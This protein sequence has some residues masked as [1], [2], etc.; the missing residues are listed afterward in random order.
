M[1]IV[2]ILLLTLSTIVGF[3]Q[4]CQWDRFK[5]A[6]GDSPEGQ[7]FTDAIDADV[8]L[9]DDWEKLDNAD[10]RNVERQ[11]STLEPEQIGPYLKDISD[12][13]PLARKFEGG[14]ISVDSWKILNETGETGLVSRVDD[15]EFVDGYIKNSEK[16]PLQVTSEI[17]DAGGYNAWKVAKTGG[18][19]ADNLTG[20]LKSTYDDLVA[21]GLKTIDDG[22]I[23]KFTDEAGNELAKITDGEFVPTK[24]IAYFK[25]EVV[26]KT[27]TGHWLIKNGDEYG[28]DLGYKDG[29]VFTSEQVNAYHRGIGNH[30]P[31]KPLNNVYERDLQI[32]DKLYIVEYKNPIGTDI[33]SPNP[34]GW[35]SKNKIST[36]QELREDLAVLEGWKDA[37]QNGGLVLREYTVKKPLPVRDGIV[38][39][40]QEVGDLIT[41]PIYRGGEQQYEFMEYLGN[42]RWEDYLSIKDKKGITL[43]DD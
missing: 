8:S 3:A 21:K 33:A 17:T 28:F 36:I 24:W 18:K 32:G 7:A 14:E 41:A 11:L 34:G 6:T 43:I 40:L 39:P 16:T 35:G 22:N 29:R 23:I 30:S 19:L 25:G 38:G 2:F 31:Y 37:N 9:I 1:R 26:S 20:A 4:P 27:E 12:N 15:I 13:I 5:Q 10:I 42:G